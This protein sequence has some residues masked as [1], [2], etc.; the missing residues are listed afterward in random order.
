LRRIEFFASQF[1]FCDQAAEQ[2]EYKTKDTIKL[3]GLDPA[4]VLAEDTG[5]DRVKDL[6]GL[7]QNGLSVRALMT[8][9]VFGKAMAF[10]RGNQ[11]TSLEDF[12]QILPFVFHDKLTPNLEAP[13]FEQEGKRKFRVDR[14]GWIRNMFDLAC[15][16]Y[17]RLDLDKDDP[18]GE[19]SRNLATGFEGV[20][21]RQADQILVRIEKILGEWSEGRK[22]YGH[23]HDDIL[24]L[25]YLHQRYSNYLRWL[26]WE[27]S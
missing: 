10:F 20:S 27:K 19:L 11:E 3:S 25:K 23:M 5:K 17:D 24:K 14:I 4:L 22:L 13:F 8:L 2:F 6:G 21:E 18:V 15:A 9:L 7:T 1:E 12:R 16:E 26:R